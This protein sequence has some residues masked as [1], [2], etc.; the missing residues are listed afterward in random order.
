MRPR[1]L[2]KRKTKEKCFV[3]IPYY[4]ED[5]KKPYKFLLVPLTL[6]IFKTKI[7]S[8]FKFNHEDPIPNMILFFSGPFHFHFKKISSFKKCEQKIK[9]S[10]VNT[11]T[12]ERKHLNVCKCFFALCTCAVYAWCLICCCCVLKTIEQAWEM[13]F[14]VRGQQYYL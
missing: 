14:S 12:K 3:R 6:Q 13:N 8:V 5:I 7:L 10:L 1:F 2:T 9:R 4:S 11:R